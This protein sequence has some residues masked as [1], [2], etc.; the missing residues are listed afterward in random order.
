MH[1]YNEITNEGVQGHCIT[2]Q[3]SRTPKRRANIR[4]VVYHTH[5]KKVTDIVLILGFLIVDAFFFHDIFKVG[6][7]TTLPQYM[8]GLLSI[9][10]FIRCGYSLLAE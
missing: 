5:M 7:V 3:S 10:V 8:T 2:K 9:L 1:F 4:S 6:D